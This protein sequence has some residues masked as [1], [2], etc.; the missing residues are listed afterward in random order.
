LLVLK[1]FG[2]VKAKTVAASAIF[3]AQLKEKQLLLLK[4]S[5]PVQAKIVAI[6]AFFLPSIWLKGPK[7]WA[8]FDRNWTKPTP[9]LNLTR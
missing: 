8:Q 6:T 4:F 5:G 3:L 1:F 7:N 2:P 9:L